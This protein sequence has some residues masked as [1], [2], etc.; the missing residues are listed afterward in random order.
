MIGWYAHHHGAG[1]LSRALVVAARMT[2]PVTILSSAPRP[3]HW[4]AKRWVSLPMDTAPEGLDHTAGGVLHWAPLRDEGYA[5]RMAD[6][7][8]WVH[9]E[10]P[11]LLVTDVSAEV[12]LLGRLLGVPVV[13]FLMAGDRSD[14]AHEI[15]YDAATALV[16]PWPTEAGLV[17]GWRPAWAAKATFVG[18]LSRFDDRV[19]RPAPGER[20]VTVLWGRGGSVVTDADLDAARAATPRWTWTVCSAAG[21]DE[22]WESLQCAD[23][24]VAHSGQNVV[25]EVAAA[26]RRAVI[27]AQP[28]PHDEQAHLVRSLAVAG[29]AQGCL[30]WPDPQQWPGLLECAA[31]T[32]PARWSWWS[33]G[34][35]ADRCAAHLDH[36][37]AGGWS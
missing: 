35:G 13:V 17:T 22:V 24:V 34:H 1:H 16:A 10:R 28:R 26:R 7:A 31:P 21:P 18:A 29:L 30:G 37:A 12:G 9:L 15:S 3:D 4:P 20:R 19:A 36:L 23:V 6:I 2:S 32:D 11:Q 27:I 8:R 14:R 33:D 25:A 5:G